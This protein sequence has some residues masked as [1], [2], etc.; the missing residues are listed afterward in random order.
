MASPMTRT[1]YSFL[2]VLDR[3]CG[4]FDVFLLDGIDGVIRR[5]IQTVELVHV[6]PDSQGGID[7][8]SQYDVSHPG[9]G[10]ELIKEI[11]T[12]ENHHVDAAWY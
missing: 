5:Q 10:A 4:I 8:T 9:N 3:S 12:G 7:I 6:G 11:V 2:S 1:K